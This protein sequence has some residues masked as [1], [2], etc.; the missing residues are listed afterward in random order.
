M[1]GVIVICIKELIVNKF[2]K[3]KWNAVLKMSGIEQE[4]VIIPT[5]DVDDSLCLKV[6][7]SICKVL[8]LSLQQVADAFGEYWVCE[9]A[10]KIYKAYYIG[11]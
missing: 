8:N 1:K 9:F 7:D 11:G 2:G 3:D 5:S 4:P 10:P 6:I